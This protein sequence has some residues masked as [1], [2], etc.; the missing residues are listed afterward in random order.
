MSIYLLLAAVALQWTPQTSGSIASLRGLSVVS[1]KV[2]WASGSKGTVLRSADG[3]EHWLARK[4]GGAEALDFRDVVAFDA[5]TALVM[6][7]GE[8]N[9]RVYLTRDGGELWTLVLSDPDPKG[10]FDAMKFWDREHGILLGDPVDGHFTIYTTANGG[11][12]W[13]RQAGPAATP[14]EGA[15]AASGTCLAVHAKTN[16]WFGTGGPEVARVFH[17]ADGGETW[18]VAATPMF[19]STTAS[20][21]FSLVFIDAEHGVA[22]GGD[23]QKPTQADRTL[24]LT[25]NAGDTWT[26]AAGGIAGGFRSAVAYVKARKLLIA[27]GTSGSDYS[28]DIGASW[29]K[30]SSDALNAV[31]SDGRAVWAVGPKGLILKLR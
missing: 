18:T 17:T 22:V 21:I 14:R 26:A 8:G 30:L 7:A 13:T 28:L 31:G 19:G 12:T 29:T 5:K 2:V 16:A 25:S 6:A 23:Y 10:F 24:G 15:F 4:V 9:A 11:A 27:V 20:G 1:D 3:G